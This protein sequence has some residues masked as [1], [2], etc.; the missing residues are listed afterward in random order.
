MEETCQG[1]LT[2]NHTM[3][4]FWQLKL[5]EEITLFVLD[6]TLVAEPSFKFFRPIIQNNPAKQTVRLITLFFLYKSERSHINLN[7]TLKESRKPGCKVYE[8]L[9]NLKLAAT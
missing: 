3:L 4:V 6:L 7:V 5:I 1:I 2:P 8:F 9:W